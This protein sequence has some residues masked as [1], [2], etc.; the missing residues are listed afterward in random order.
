MWV[1]KGCFWTYEVRNKFPNAPTHSAEYVRVCVYVC[2]HV[3]MSAYDICRRSSMISACVNSSMC[4]YSNVILQ[5]SCKNIQVQ[6]I[7]HGNTG[8]KIQDLWT[9]CVHEKQIAKIWEVCEVTYMYIETLEFIL[10]LPCTD[11]GLSRD[12]YQDFFTQRL[13]FHVQIQYVNCGRWSHRLTDFALC[14][15]PILNGGC[16]VCSKVSPLFT[17][18]F[19]MHAV[20]ENEMRNQHMK[21]TADITYFF[22][23]LNVSSTIFFKKIRSTWDNEGTFLWILQENLG[24]NSF[25]LLSHISTCLMT[26]RQQTSFKCFTIFKSLELSRTKTLWEV[27][28][29]P[30]AAKICMVCTYILQT[31]LLCLYFTRK[32]TT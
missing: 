2:V 20:Q 24:V 15:S 32:H 5:S 29:Q 14:L 16:K 1:S 26:L 6:L 27:S 21:S 25:L 23:V 11:F 13:G 30:Q 31:L 3:H 22:S 4:M 28:I 9:L 19:S 18:K 17:S 10:T 12:Y 7:K 8:D